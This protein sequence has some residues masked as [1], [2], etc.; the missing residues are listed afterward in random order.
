[1]TNLMDRK[2][3]WQRAADGLHAIPSRPEQVLPG[4]EIRTLCGISATLTREDFERRL[5]NGAP[6]PTCQRC[7]TAWITRESSASTARDDRD[8]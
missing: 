3:Q 2:F 5:P 1:M 4:D 6:A 8:A 7:T